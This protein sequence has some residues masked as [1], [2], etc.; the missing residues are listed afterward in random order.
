[1]IM[2]DIALP[3]LPPSWLTRT[4]SALSRGLTAALTC[5]GLT[6]RTRPWFSMTPPAAAEFCRDSPL[7]MFVVSFVPAAG[8]RPL[9]RS[10]PAGTGPS[11]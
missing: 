2:C 10:S 6:S 7:E 4:L 9:R 8:P 11:R 3:A 5:S 1:M